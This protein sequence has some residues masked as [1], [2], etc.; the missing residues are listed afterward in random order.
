MDADNIV[1][2]LASMFLC[3]RN[4]VSMLLGWSFCVAIMEFLYWK[5]GVSVLQGSSCHMAGHLKFVARF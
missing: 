4:G 1:D 5:D 3:S 2:C